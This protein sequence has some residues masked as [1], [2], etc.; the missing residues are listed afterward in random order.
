VVI[1]TGDSHIHNVGVVPVRDDELDGPA[2]ATEFLG[3]S[4]TSGGYGAA[5]TAMSKAYMED[6]PHFALVNQQ[7]GYQSFDITSKA[8]HTDVK[9]M[10]RVQVPGG[11]LGML[12]RF[13]VTPDKPALHVGQTIRVS[14]VSVA[15]PSDCAQ[16]L[17]Q[18]R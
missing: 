11:K 9:V 7:R 12:A 15:K 1:A 6:N 14:R 3:T 2:A 8:W 16:L 13:T 18:L 4:I 17:L 5:E 10:D